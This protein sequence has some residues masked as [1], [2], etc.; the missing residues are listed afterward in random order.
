MKVKLVEYITFSLMSNYII[1]NNLACCNKKKGGKG[2][3]GSGKDKGK[4]PTIINNEQQEQ[5]PEDLNKKD[6]INEDENKN[7]DEEN[8]KNPKEELID[9]SEKANLLKIYDNLS[10]NINNLIKYDSNKF[11]VE[12]INVKR[13]DI[14]NCKKKDVETVKNNIK[15]DRDKFND[16]I[17]LI[18]GDLAAKYDESKIKLENDLNKKKEYDLKNLEKLKGEISKQLQNVDINDIN[19][20]ADFINKIVENCKNFDRSINDLNT[21]LEKGVE[22]YK[23]EKIK[24]FKT[25]KDEF[26]FANS[27]IEKFNYNLDEKIGELDKLNEFQK[28]QVLVNE[29]ES[30][31]TEITKFIN[32]NIGPYNIMRFNNNMIIRCVKDILDNFIEKKELDEYLISDNIKNKIEDNQAT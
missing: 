26:N 18:Y 1:F 21:Y 24:Y 20:D 15:S 2:C 8:L 4:D 25:L 17:T 6:E 9:E 5:N 32:K 3:S 28:I 22:E 7:K 30:K 13:E 11:N 12:N 10:N 16:K 19:K 14:E 27:V 31:N 23:K 29:I